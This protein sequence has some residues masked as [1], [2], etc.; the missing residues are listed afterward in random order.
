MNQH[1]TDLALADL[2]D[3]LND[4]GIEALALRKGRG[5]YRQ[6]LV[7][8]ESEIQKAQE[9]I[10]RLKLEL[11]IKEIGGRLASIEPRIF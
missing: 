10:D 8:N 9:L 2:T 4:E 11:W 3:Y 6:A 1:I 7:I 5:Q